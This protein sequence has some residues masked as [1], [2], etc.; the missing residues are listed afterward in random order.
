MI[1]W[2]APC[3]FVALAST[4]RAQRLEA[5]RTLEITL[6]AEDPLLAGHGPSRSFEYVMD[7]DGTLHVWAASK[8]F[9]PILRIAR[10]D[11]TLL[12]EDDDSGGGTT[13][14]VVLT[15]THGRRCTLTVASKVAGSAGR[16]DVH[17]SEVAEGHADFSAERTLIGEANAALKTSD[18]ATAR[19]K[20][21]AVVDALLA[22]GD[23]GRGKAWLGLLDEVGQLA[24]NAQDTRA[25]NRAWQSALDA[26]EKALPDEH[27]DL[28]RSRGNLAVTIREL[29][30]LQG[31]RL[32]EEKVLEV[33]SRTLPD[34][35]PDLQRA[36]MNL[37]A[38]KYSLG[39]VHGARAQ[40]EKLVEV[41]S[42]T[43][44]EGDT[45]LQRARSNL[46]VTNKVLGDLHGA[47]AQFE[48][49]VEVYSRTLPDDHPELQGARMNLAAT[50]L[51]L[52][53]L[54]GARALQEKVLAVSS[55]TLPDEHPA[56]QRARTNL[57]ATL[58]A[59]RDLQGARALQEKV[60]EVDSRNLPDEHP[61]LQ[62]AR[63]N[64]AVTIGDLGDLQGALA[65]KEK[66]L[67]V[68]SRT[69]PDDHP[70]LQ[71]ARLNVA[72]S[73]RMLGELQRAHVLEAK[74]VEVRSSTL[75]DEHPQLQTARQTLAA[76]LFELGDMRGA[77]EQ[78]EKVVE[79]SSRTL[80][81]D[82]PELQKARAS[83]TIAIAAEIACA[84]ARAEARDES[85]EARARCVELIA[86]RCRS[87]TS[88][89]RAVLLEA[90]PR[91]AEAR[92]RAL[93]D[94]LDYALSLGLG[95]GVFA[96]STELDAPCF[97]LSE[98]TRGAALGSARLMRLAGNSPRY[99]EL[100]SELETRNAELATLARKGVTSEEL[101]E[102]LARRES[103]ERELVALA[104]DLAGESSP[105]LQLDADTLAAKLAPED[106]VVAFRRY[107]RRSLT[108]A[109]SEDVSSPTLVSELSVD[110]LCAF[111]V[112][113]K[114]AGGNA[115]LLARVELGPIAA[116][117]SAVNTWR[118]GL[119]VEA[120]RG[121]TV[122]AQPASATLTERGH[123]LRRLL[124]DPLAEQLA[125]ASCVILVLDDVLHLVPFD[126]LPR[127]GSAQGLLGDQLRIET[128][129]TVTELLAVAPAPAGPGHL[130][131]VGDVAF[132]SESTD[133][134]TTA[135]D[136]S[137]ALASLDAASPVLPRRELP[138]IL[139]GGSF[140]GFGRL[141]STGPEVD[142][143]ATSFAKAFGSQGEAQVLRKADATRERLI[144][145]A[146][147][148]RW[149][150][151]ATHGWF[152]PESICSWQDP[153]PL[154]KH[155]GLG[156]SLSGEEQVK[157][158]SPMLLCGLALAGAN[159]P[160]NELGRAPGLITAD[161]I[162]AL[163]LTNC[164]LAVLSACDTNV[165]ER[166]AG[167][168]VASLQKALQMAGARSVI[169]SL[170][171]VPDE[172]TKDL[173]LD[174]YRRLW[175]EKKPKWQALW[176][177]K[178]KLRDAKGP[179]GKPMYTTRDWA[180]WVLT[181]DPN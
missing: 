157:G 171:K 14:Y 39:D 15:V 24:R 137:T 107:V 78:L 51:D 156:M 13:A 95:Y 38:T 133:R 75:P 9:D 99:A 52:G 146:P 174:F 33:L 27:P 18:Y 21:S 42:R 158:M 127:G 69:L 31:A 94:G 115:A 86:A 12:T 124:F 161:E 176:E 26:R 60:L 54:H 123:A 58:H 30:D 83:L 89:A 116:I 65:L 114:D 88:A 139:R 169:T 22:R 59:L 110:S 7:C 70:D 8:D 121:L 170:W 47:R 147:R 29:G 1:H 134:D 62:R 82:H 155:T 130:V 151:V 49:V 74:V 112:R 106:A 4:P 50:M 149:L 144:E 128:R 35:H 131:A 41:Y 5:D 64:L 92:C 46:A 71:A 132:D 173:M 57:S 129:A 103:V 23:T 140:G 32:L 79:V 43:L 91:E 148:A 61:D 172:A 126:A 120:G 105:G 135:L 63:N 81:D 101:R 119:G 3:A 72:I 36:R 56:L 177:A 16:L 109:R 118:E 162:A 122:T 142:A 19:A 25:A 143:L 11:G 2:L 90:S 136:S 37:A 40:F 181:G 68:L 160:E 113:R 168:G 96:R 34:E 165:G 84:S 76:T 180:A 163:D 154:D 167:Q 145:V 100:E 20:A 111:V 97:V 73:M 80:P 179:D 53:D 77:R 153:E 67:D 175:V 98:T 117:E 28:Q 159:L 102:A 108:I 152:A 150:H 178:Q 17:V 104:R 164:E 85:G 6:G 10:A 125:D 141:P 93:G 138:G 48:K 87:Q 166:R 55:R 44:P 66:V 45:E